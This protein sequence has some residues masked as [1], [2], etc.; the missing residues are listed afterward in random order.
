MD[1]EVAISNTAVVGRHR[2]RRL[3]EIATSRFQR[4]TWNS[5]GNV[6][7]PCSGYPSGLC[8]F[9]GVMVTDSRQKDNGNRRE[10]QE[11]TSLDETNDATHTERS[12]PIVKVPCKALSL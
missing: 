3:G 12:T 9:S 1:R 2:R 11:A 6:D 8:Y 4:Q 10:L 5:N 7:S